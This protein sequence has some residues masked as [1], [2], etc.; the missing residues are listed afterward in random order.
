LES[1]KINY[2]IEFE[3]IQKKFEMSGL[4]E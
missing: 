2:P 4:D 1:E 3:E